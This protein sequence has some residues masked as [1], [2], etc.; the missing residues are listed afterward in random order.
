MYTWILVCVHF[1]ALLLWM[2]LQQLQHEG[3]LQGRTTFYE[4]KLELATDEVQRATA[5]YEREKQQRVQLT[6]EVDS[7][8]ELAE[9][10]QPLITQLSEQKERNLQLESKV[11]GC[12]CCY[13]RSCVCSSCCCHHHYSCL[14]LKQRLL[15]L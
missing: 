1:S 2:L 6:N 7:L 4:Q 3:L 15:L 12:S 13:C 10:V 14:R 5:N 8:T 9:R 11:S